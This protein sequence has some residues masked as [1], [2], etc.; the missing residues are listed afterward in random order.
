MMLR[1]AP[2]AEVKPLNQQTVRALCR[3]SVVTPY[4]RFDNVYV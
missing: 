3:K 2:G 4:V 1:C